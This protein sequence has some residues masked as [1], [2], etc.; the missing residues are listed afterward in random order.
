MLE[1]IESTYHLY[2]ATRDERHLDALE[3]MTTALERTRT[4]CG[5]ACVVDVTREPWMLEDRQDR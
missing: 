4:K 3:R 2:R 5:F 1:L